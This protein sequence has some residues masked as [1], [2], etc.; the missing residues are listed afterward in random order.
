MRCVWAA[1]RISTALYPPMWRGRTGASLWAWIMD[2]W[3]RVLAI[4]KYLQLF[5]S[6]SSVKVCRIGG[7]LPC[8]CWGARRFDAVAGLS[9]KGKNDEMVGYRIGRPSSV[10]ERVVKMNL[11]LGRRHICFWVGTGWFLALNKCYYHSRRRRSR[12][13][14][15]LEDVD[16]NRHRRPHSCSGYRNNR[17]I[18]G[19][20]APHC[21]VLHPT[22]T[23]PRT[24][25]IRDCNTENLKRKLLT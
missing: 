13:A 17:D 20:T 18:P 8:P 7:I 12:V 14:N 24:L 25:P 11:L 2:A 4:C 15:M 6:Y 9:H 23:F 1:L 10:S 22:N 3:L 5:K 19:P 21:T 16:L